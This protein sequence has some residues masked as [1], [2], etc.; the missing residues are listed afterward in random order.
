[1]SLLDR[2]ARH[3]RSILLA[4]AIVL[5]FAL[6]I[7]RQDDGLDPGD[8]TSIPGDLDAFLV[9]LFSTDGCV[10]AS[11][12]E[13]AV[14]GELVQ[15]G[16]EPEWRVVLRPEVGADTCVGYAAH[17]GRREIRLIAALRPEVRIALEK[18]RDQLLGECLDRNSAV[19]VLRSALEEEDERD[20]LIRTDG[21]VGG[22]PGEYSAVVEHV[23]DGCF[24]YST[25][26]WTE[27]GI[28]LYY[29]AGQP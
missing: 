11:D 3:W 22:P 10:R 25:T 24:V 6:P 19:E 12:A 2:V 15:L 18:V 9:D 4:G 17:S 5:L 8:E 26:G 27:D 21:P 7:M 28:R 20:F 14:I 23:M 29:L 16:L 1:M 13:D